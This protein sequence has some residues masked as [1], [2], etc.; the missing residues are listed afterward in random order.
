M[1]KLLALKQLYGDWDISFDNLYRFKAQVESCCPGSIVQIDHHTI[2]GK[3]RFRRIFVA[4]KPCIEGFLSGCRPYLAIDSTF[5]TGRFKGQLASATAI[6]GHN[7]MYPVSFGVFDSETNENWIWFMQL[8]RQAI[9]SPNGLAICTDAGQAVMTGVKEVFPEAEHR[10]CMFHL[11]TNFKKKFHGKVFDDHLWA[12]AYSWNPYLFDKHWVAMETTKPTATAYMRKWHNRLWSRSQFSTICKVDYVTNNLAE[13]F[14]NWVKHHKSLNLD[15]LFDKARQLI[16]ILWNRRRKVANELD[17]LILP[18]IIKKLNAMTGEL[19]LEVVES[20]EEVAEATALGG[21]GFRFV[22]NLQEGTCSC[23]QWQV[24]GHPCK[25]ALAF[26]TSLSNA[27]IRHYVD[28]YFSIDKYRAA[29]AQLIP[30]MP[31]KTQ[32][33]K[34]DHG[35]FM[36]P[37]LLK[38]TAGRR[39]TER[40]KGCG[41]KERKS[42]QHLCPICKEYGH[43]WHKCKKGNPEDIAAMMAVR[44]PPKKRTKTTKTAELSIVPCEDGVPTRMCFPQAK[45]WKLQPKKGEAC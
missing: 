36:H 9:G 8:L 25:H 6:D 44:E 42:G 23:R 5:L 21:S 37:P 31:D 40:Y 43:R 3:I 16:M 27:H 32:W 39:K 28:L 17:G 38:A 13:S 33:P 19:N 26:I 14:N 35:F 2:N 1:G 11:V 22:V 4:M 30:A 12:A 34:S 7:W 20:S 41:E 18:H 10:E 29:Y 15:D 24:S 45:A